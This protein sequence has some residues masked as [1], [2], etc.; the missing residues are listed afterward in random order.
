MKLEYKNIKETIL[1]NFQCGEKELK[2]N[3]FNDELNKILTRAILAPGASIGLHKH[4]TS[5]EII[6]IISGEGLMI[7]DDNEE[8][9][10]SGDVHYC[11]KGSSHTFKNN[12]DKDL[13]FFAVVPQQ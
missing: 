10:Q 2:A 4:E 3:I 6:Y 8:L 13:I 9:L 11:K 5:S 7:C 1:P 12:S